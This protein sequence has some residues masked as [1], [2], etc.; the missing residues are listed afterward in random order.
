[1]S[2]FKKNKTFFVTGLAIVAILSASFIWGG[3]Y[4]KNP[5]S[6]VGATKVSFEKN[7]STSNLSDKDAS[8]QKEDMELQENSVASTDDEEVS[9]SEASAV[10]ESKNNE[11]ES[12]GTKS[13]AVS[14]LPSKE[15]KANTEVTQGKEQHQTDPVTAEKPVAVEPQNIEITDKNYS[16]TLSVRCDSI[17]NNMS[18]I[19]EDKHDI[20][21]EDGVI[22][23]A[24][25]VAFYEGESVFN[26]L[27]RE[28]KKAKISMEFMNTPVYNSAYIEGINNLYEFDVGELSGWMYKVNGW[29]PNYG[30]SRYQLKDGDVI[31]WEYTCNLGK[32]IGGNNS[33]EGAD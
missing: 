18:L 1:M 4:S 33:A 14:E 2:Y 11:S 30:C 17:L 26:V 9:A 25:T 3:N 32:D 23:P 5:S 20:V 28:M 13:S 19:S 24:T 31:E 21:P 16:C 27:Q 15:T 22:F 8:V 6:E 29:F 10:T 7:A 12:N